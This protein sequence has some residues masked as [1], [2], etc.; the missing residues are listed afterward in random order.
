MC[1][2]ADSDTCIQ[3]NCMC[4]CH[5]PFLWLQGIMEMKQASEKKNAPSLHDSTVIV[6]PPESYS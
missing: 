3:R 5:D 6:L 1:T 4:S 2:C